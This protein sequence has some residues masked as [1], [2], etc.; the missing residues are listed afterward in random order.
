M[1]TQ[2]NPRLT[3]EAT[4]EPPLTP[5]VTHYQQVADDFMKS[6][7][8]LVEVMPKFEISHST[9]ARFVRTHQNVS[10]AFLATV[11]S[12]VSQT[13]ELQAVNKL[14]VVAARDALQFIDAFRPVLDKISA[15]AS[16]LRFTL[17]S[18]R[19]VLVADALQIYAIAKGVA[20]DARGAAVGLHVRNMKRDL[21]KRGGRPKEK[22]P[23]ETPATPATS[24]AA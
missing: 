18:E 22:A 5:T 2:K 6:L 1:S 10:D 20:R 12:A 11:L 3:K 8:S 4:A 15:V 23:D 14:D 16:S 13:P 21:G 9:T 7:D 17:D 24:K 19:A